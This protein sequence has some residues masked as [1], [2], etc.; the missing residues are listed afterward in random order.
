M[1]IKVVDH[2]NLVEELPGDNGNAFSS[3]K[4]LYHKIKVN[5]EMVLAKEAID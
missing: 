3:S 5:E 4:R 1:K 2:L